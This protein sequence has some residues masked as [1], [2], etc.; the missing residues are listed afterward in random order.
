MNQ[1]QYR[2]SQGLTLKAFGELIGVAKMTAWRYENGDAPAPKVMQRI[3]EVTDGA[4][5]VR[6]YYGQHAWE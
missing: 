5:D 2:T 1:K 4:I 3:L 6:T